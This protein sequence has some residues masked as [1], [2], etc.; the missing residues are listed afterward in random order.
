VTPHLCDT[1][2]LVITV[3]PEPPIAEVD[4][5]ATFINTPVPGDLS[6][7]DMDP[8][9]LRLKYNTTPIA[10]PKHGTVTIDTN[11]LYIYTPNTG[12]TG[13]DSFRYIVCDVPLGLC[14]TSWAYIDILPLDSG[15]NPPL[16]LNDYFSTLLNVNIPGTVANN[17]LDPDWDPLTF[18]LLQSPLHGVEG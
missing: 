17:D 8:Q 2:T 4:H 16:A 7:N 18:T 10:L 12:Y 1:A 5:N 15:N 9:G 3:V 14:D 11:G 13:Q 6:T